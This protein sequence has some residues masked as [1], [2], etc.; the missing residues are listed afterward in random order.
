LSGLEEIVAALEPE[1]GK[2]EGDPAPLE[3][4]I[5]NRNYRA[6]FGGRD[7]LL[8]IP[9]KDTDQ[10]GIDR[11]AERSAN[12]C[13]AA[14]GVAPPV[15]VMLEEPPCLV[16]GFVKGEQMTPADLRKPAVV[17]EVARSLRSIHESGASVPT[18]FDSFRLVE[19]YEETA[20]ENGVEVPDAYAKA[21]RCAARIEQAL[22]GAEHESVLCHNDL[23]AGNFLQ[24]GRIWI[25]DWEYSGMGDRYFDLANFAVNNEL[26]AKA[27]REFLTAYWDEEPSAGR[28]AALRLMKFM[29]DFREAMWGV[30]Q[31]GISD[32]EFDFAGYAA[33]HFDRLTATGAQPEFE[34]WIEE[35]SAP[36]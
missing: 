9:G 32:L 1:L 14:L 36:S 17:G 19:E 20:E 5:T 33:K 6:R 31:Q 28:L 7:Y 35:A 3:G 12:E 26:G 27:E 34:I 15:A 25:V 10:L 13:A 30:V 2:L 4:G 29:S 21:A 23:L 22:E 11:R 8:R 18:T 16:T 24:G